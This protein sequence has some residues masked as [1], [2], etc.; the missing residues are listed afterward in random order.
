[1]ESQAEAGAEEDEEE[2]DDDIAEEDHDVAHEFV[3]PEELAPEDEWQESLQP[4][5][6]QGPPPPSC[7][8]CQ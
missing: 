4:Y 1:M 8:H 2:E 5:L 3:K 6:R 7:V